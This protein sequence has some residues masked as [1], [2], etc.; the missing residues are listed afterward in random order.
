MTERN[1]YDGVFYCSSCGK[2]LHVFLIMIAK[3]GC[4]C[5]SKGFVS[6]TDFD[7]HESLTQAEVMIEETGIKIP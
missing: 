2:P 3:I 4:E 1:L 5:G 7:I 6:Y